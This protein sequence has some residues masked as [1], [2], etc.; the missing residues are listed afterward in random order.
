MIRVQFNSFSYE[1][2]VVVTPFIGEIIFS[3]LSVLD[4]LLEDQLTICGLIS[5]FYILFCWSIVL[6]QHHTFFITVALQYI[7]K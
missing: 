5:G 6:Y 3:P 4:I 7:F 1:Y 2:L